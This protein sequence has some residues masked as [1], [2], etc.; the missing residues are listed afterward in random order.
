ML[1]LLLRSRMEALLSV[2]TGASRTKKAQSKGKLIG[3]ALLMLLS[4]FSFGTLFARIFEMLGEPFAKMNLGWLYFA[5]AAVLCFGVMVIGNV[6]LAKYQLFEAKDNDLL[7]SMPVKPLDILLSRLFLL[8]VLAWLVMLPV[9]VPALIFWPR[10]LGAAGIVSVLCQFAVVLP[11]LNLAVSALLGWLVHRV[12]SR[13]RNNTLVS[14]VF[15]LAFLGAYMYFNFRMNSMLTA[16]AAD[17]SGLKKSLGSA[18]PLVWIGRSIA[19]G[20]VDFLLLMLG[21]ALL[22]FGLCLWLLSRTFVKTAT[23]K[24]SAAKRVYVERTAEAHGPRAA[25]LRHELRRLFSSS[26]YLL[27]GALGSFFVLAA[28]VFVLIRG[29]TLTASPDWATEPELFRGLILVGLCWMSTLTF[30]TA[31]SISLEGRVLWIPKSLP[32]SSWDVLQAKLRLHMLIALPPTLL[33]S[34]AVGLC[35]DYR[36]ELLALVLLLPALYCVFSGLL[37]LFENLRHPN[38]NWINETQAVKSGASVVL[39]ML[40]GMGLVLLPVLACLLFG[41]WLRV[42]QVGWT[43]LALLAALSL[44]LWLWLRKKGPAIFEAL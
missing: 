39:T 7:L 23:A 40:I 42:E 12:S 8:L 11:L 27:N 21:I 18:A 26:A 29:R 41:S 2:L 19:E 25:L 35:L 6:I 13:S 43:V 10:P 24:S 33:A 9:A 30:I 32:V 17:P 37:G 36:G 28:A 34:L 3:F 4:L 1:R 44:L 22:L 14:L 16:L 5:L 31:P 38:F 20:R 15:T